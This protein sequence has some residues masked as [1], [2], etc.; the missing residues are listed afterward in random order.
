MS[1]CTRGCTSAIMTPGQAQGRVEEEGMVELLTIFN[2]RQRWRFTKV[3]NTQDK[4][5]SHTS[6]RGNFT[7]ARST[8]E[9]TRLESS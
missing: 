6:M 9:R 2:P 7:E 1:A 4:V 3:N 8:I 5:Q